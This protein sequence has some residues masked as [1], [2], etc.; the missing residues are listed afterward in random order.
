MF[1]TDVIVKH[2][3]QNL[4]SFEG[5]TCEMEFD[6]ATNRAGTIKEIIFW[7]GLY[8]QFSF[9]HATMMPQSETLGETREFQTEAPP[10]ILTP[11]YWGE[12]RCRV[13][14]TADKIP[15]PKSTNEPTTIQCVGTCARNAP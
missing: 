12:S 6:G 13:A 5:V 8:D 3:A 1:S 11:R 7:L 14:F 9:V 2:F 10:R 15:M 4:F